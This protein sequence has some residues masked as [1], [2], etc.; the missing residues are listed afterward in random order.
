MTDT[1]TR[2]EHL[3]WAKQRAIELLDAGKSTDALASIASDLQ[4]H[5][6]TRNH[7]GIMLMGMM[8]LGG[9]LKTEKSVRDL[10]EGFN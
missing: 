10:I 2:A 7:P 4:K 8:A 5:S 9:Y 6:E 1:R 3:A